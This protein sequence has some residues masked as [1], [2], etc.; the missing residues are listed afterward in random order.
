MLL[1]E[2]QIRHRVRFQLRDARARNIIV[3]ARVERLLEQKQKQDDA[4][5]QA[6]K[7]LDTLAQTA[8]SG[9]NKLSKGS[10]SEK[11]IAEIGVGATAFAAVVS[12]SG[13][14]KLLGYLA[15]G[16]AKILKKLGAN[17]DPEKE[18]KTFFD[19]S[20]HIHHSYIGVLKKLAGLF[21][22]DN[23]QQ[24]LAANVMFGVLLGVAAWLTGE[25]IYHA[26]SNNN[27]LTAMGEGVLQGIKVAEGSSLSTDMFGLVETTLDS[28]GDISLE[29]ADVED[30]VAAI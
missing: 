3:N 18:G 5:D 30:I 4:L 20:E 11:E 1:S 12:A 23:A 25:G 17:V 29:L 13:I 10:T 26:I 14:A 9:V 21:V 15:K 28:I 6:K 7:E 22:K 24:D 27:A 16:I 2:A 19:I 8:R